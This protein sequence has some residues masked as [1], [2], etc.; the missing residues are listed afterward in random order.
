LFGCGNDI[1]RCSPAF[2]LRL[3]LMLGFGLLPAPSPASANFVVNQPWLRPAKVAQSTEAYMNLTSGQ[4]AHLIGV[5]TDAAAGA[6]I[7]GPGAPI[8]K[9]ARVALPSGAMVAL[10]PGQY[11]IALTRLLRPLQLGDRV[12]LTLVMEL[13]DGTRQDI[14]VDAEVRRRSPIDDERRAESHAHRAH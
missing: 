1:M 9:V 8:A 3:A 7:R 2:G 12:Q 10:A 13:D 14:E 11:R 4:G 6:S 5:R